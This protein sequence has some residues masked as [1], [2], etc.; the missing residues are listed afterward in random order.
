M[1]NSYDLIQA[2]CQLALL[3]AALVRY[4]APWLKS[5]KVV[6]RDESGHFA[7][8]T[9]KKVSG[10]PPSTK[11]RT[12]D[13]VEFPHPDRFRDAELT[14]LKTSAGSS[15]YFTADVDGQK[16]F[17]KRRNSSFFADSAAKEELAT[18]V[19]KVM[20]IE[21]HVIPSKR[22]R[23]KGRDYSA[24]PFTEG[25]NLFETDKTVSELLSEKEITKLGLFDYV[26]ANGTKE[27][28]KLADHEATFTGLADF[29]GELADAFRAQAGK[30]TKQD[31]QSVLD[32]EDKLLKAIETTIEDEEL[33]KVYAR[34]V[35]G[36]LGALQTI[37]NSPDIGKAINLM[38][39]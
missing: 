6:L 2:R 11:V 20:E 37:A 36:R 22:V 19:A 29:E 25:E 39:Q 13:T 9:T 21:K 24:S 8:Q 38:M 27:G 17:L 26:I 33:A 28:L 35:R 30:V 7:S 10:S 4:P 1:L 3:Q 12:G 14:P 5:A 18:E 34:T 32:K 31:I 16:Y 15:S 23:I